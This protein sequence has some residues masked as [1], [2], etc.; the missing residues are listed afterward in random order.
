MTSPYTRLAPAGNET[1]VKVREDALTPETINVP[2]NNDDHLLVNS[3]HSSVPSTNTS[4]MIRLG[5]VQ[6]LI[7]H[8]SVDPVSMDKTVIVWDMIAGVIE[9][10]FSSKLILSD[11]LN[12]V[13]IIS[14]DHTTSTHD[15]DDPVDTDQLSTSET[16]PVNSVPVDE[17]D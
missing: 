6:V 2:V 5:C 12:P 10:W 1:L 14:P 8:M 15:H 4:E 17:I 11:S 16:M 13:D 3:N 7:H 9:C